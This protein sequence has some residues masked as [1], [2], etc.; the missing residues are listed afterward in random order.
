MNAFRWCGVDWAELNFVDV[1][2]RRKPGI[3]EKNTIADPRGL[4]Y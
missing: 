4:G 1:Q 2:G 3:N